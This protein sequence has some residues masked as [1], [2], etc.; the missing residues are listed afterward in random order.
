MMNPIRIGAVAACTSLVL[1]C[2]GGGGGSSSPSPPVVS[3]S[4]DVKQG[5]EPLQVNFDA[6]NSSD[7]QRQPLTYAWSFSD[8]GTASGATVSHTFQKHGTYTATVVV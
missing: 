4:S 8:G 3:A 2:G 7:P 1:G 5:Q 6:S